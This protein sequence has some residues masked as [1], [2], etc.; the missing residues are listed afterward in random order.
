MK[1]ILVPVIVLFVATT[2]VACQS[3]KAAKTNKSSTGTYT[4]MT[5]Q[6]LHDGMSN[7]DFTLINVHIPYA[8]EIPQTDL[9]IPYNEI[10]Q[11]KDK[12]PEKKDAKL[13]LY[14][15]SGGMSAIAVKTLVN[16][17]YTNVVDIPG[18]MIAWDAAGYKLLERQAP[19]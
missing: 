6:E 14:C 18:G 12:L 8:G 19:R 10:E 7:K 2:L 9:F 15:R 5:I 11:Q 16:M 13:V 17:G 3:E 1:R 4:S